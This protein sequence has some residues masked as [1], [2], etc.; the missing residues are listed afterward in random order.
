MKLQDF[1]SHHGIKRNPFAE[2]DAQ[3]DPVFKDH[4]ISNTYHPAWDKVFGNPADPS[5][6]IVF[7][8]KG[9]GK[10][11]LRLQ[12]E[13]H[14]DEYNRDN[15]EARSFVVPYDDFNPILDQFRERVARRS[16]KPEKVLQQFQ[17][18]DHMDAIMSLAVTK[19]VSS[20][21]DG[22]QKPKTSGISNAAPSNNSPIGNQMPKDLKRR[23]DTHQRRDLMLLASLY[24]NTT[25]APLPQRWRKLRSRVG[26]GSWK[27]WWPFNLAFKVTIGVIAALIAFFVMDMMKVAVPEAIAVTPEAAEGAEAGGA[28]WWGSLVTCCRWAP[29]AWGLAVVAAW[30]PWLLRFGSRLTTASGI[31]KRIR[32]LDKPSMPLAKSLM[33]FSKSQLA[34]QPLPN[35]ERT[36]DRYS[37]MGKL[38]GILKSLGYS[39]MTVLVDRVDEPHLINGSAEAMRALL[40]P[41]LDNK[42]LKQDGMGMKFLLPA[43]LTQFIDREDRDFYQRARLDKQNMIPSLDWT[44]QALYDVASARLAAC[45]DADPPPKLAAMLD[46]SLSDARLFDSLRSMRVPRHMFKFLYRVIMAHCNKHS[47][48]AP[49][50]RIA[51]DTFES[52]LAI[53]RREQES[54]DRG[55][56]A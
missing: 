32:V 44:G 5:T 20:I 30:I 50:Y 4:C 47:D 46:E 22:P 52:E 39:S 21:V 19:L 9:A 48:A 51:T 1:L 11:A 45:S 56:G 41:M 27:S 33:R 18:W 28:T 42:F 14:I 24:D 29:W 43:E 40:W 37:L 3:T 55:L 6:S 38:Q 15:P 31:S 53:Y 36:D 13:E 12:V 16:K 49:A 25:S 26:G 54:A 8:E 34:G 7:G 17:L 23:L 2:E 35:K 10:T